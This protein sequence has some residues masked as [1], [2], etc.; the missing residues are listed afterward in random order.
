MSNRYTGLDNSVANQMAASDDEQESA[1][2]YWLYMKYAKDT[3]SE[4][5]KAGYRLGFIAANKKAL[6]S[7]ETS[8]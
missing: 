5:F 2:S 7:D 4:A 3:T 8:A 6:E 1:Y